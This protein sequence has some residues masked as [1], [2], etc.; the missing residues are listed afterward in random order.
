[1]TCIQM[2]DNDFILIIREKR[3]KK[4]LSWKMWTLK[5]GRFIRIDIDRFLFESI[6]KKR[7]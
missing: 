7:D 1:M 5:T 3:G 2:N 6:E 4:K